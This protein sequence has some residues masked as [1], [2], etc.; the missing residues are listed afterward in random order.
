MLDDPRH[1]RPRPWP[2]RELLRLA[3][4][5][6]AAASVPALGLLGHSAA[7]Q[8]A[9]PP[10]ATPLRDGLMLLGGAGGNAVLLAAP[11]GSALVD[12]GAPE[13]AAA[14]AAL[15]RSKLGGA[16]L[17]TLLNTH[18][19]PLHT[20]GNDAF[21]SSGTRIVA[22]AN[23]RLWMAT[24]YYVD[25]EDR[26]YTPRAA[27]ALP[28]DT[29]YATDPQPIALNVGGERIEYG[30][31]REAHTDGDIYVHFRDRNVLVAGGA[32]AAGAYPV[33]DY[34]TGGW[35]GGL[36]EANEKLLAITNADTLIVPHEGP[37]QPRSHLEA[38]L[39][40]LKTVRGRI[41]NL[42]RKGKSIEEML[43]ADVTA[44]FDAAWGT[45]RARFVANIY[46][47]LWWAGRLSDSL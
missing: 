10:T 11:S 41:E 35:I 18:W 39:D 30:H 25:W 27:V 7:A 2:R 3:V 20:G 43:A 26:T 8:T 36:V 33:I 32:V 4:G 42:M 6:A 28:T 14:V 1:H 23:T 44:G 19:H 40:M 37:A 21:G 22:H 12:S 9:A 45:N 13:H 24:E 17:G 34:A 46:N 31:L 38:Q 29:F 15:V 47:G 16:P 5:A